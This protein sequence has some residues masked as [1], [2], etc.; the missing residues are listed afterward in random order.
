MVNCMCGIIG[1]FGNKYKNSLKDLLDFADWNIHRGDDGVGFIFLDEE[2]NTI[3]REKHLFHIDEMMHDKLREYRAKQCKTIGSITMDSYDEEY[4]KRLNEQFQKT[5]GNELKTESKAIFLHHRKASIGSVNRKNLHPVEVNNNLFIHNGT[6]YAASYVR[7]YLEEFDDIKWNSTTDT[8]VLA[9]T[10]MDLLEKYGDSHIA[11]EVIHRLYYNFGVLIRF[12]KESKDWEIIKDDMR[13]LW[14]IYTETDEWFI[15]SEPVYLSVD[16][17]NAF[18]LG[19]GLIKPGEKFQYQDFT[20]EYN[21]ALHLW[22]KHINE[23]DLSQIEKCAV[24]DKKKYTTSISTT[25]NYFDSY[26][27][28]RCFD[29]TVRQVKRKNYGT[30]DPDTD[31]KAWNEGTF[32][33]LLFD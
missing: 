17:E 28:N 2:D 31:S 5:I 33:E 29:C 30:Q 21:E 9:K 26:L 3:H 18:K 11:Y 32:P 20:S 8:E 13:T 23:N 4:H 1:Y 22:R 7:D 6:S 16:V 19:D 25:D 14:L 27:H 12:D 15:I 24:C 10:Y